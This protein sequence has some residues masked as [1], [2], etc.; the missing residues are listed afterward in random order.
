[1]GNVQESVT[2]DLAEQVKPTIIERPPV[3]VPGSLS[4]APFEPPKMYRR[5]SG[6]AIAGVAGGLADHL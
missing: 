3:P 5:R 4:P 6:R 1:M 2:D